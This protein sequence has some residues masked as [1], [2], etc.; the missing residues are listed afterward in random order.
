MAADRAHKRG[1]TP[2]RANHNDNVTY[3]DP[4]DA[5]LEDVAHRGLAPS[6][7]PQ[8]DVVIVGAGFAG[9]SAGALLA[10]RGVRVLVLEARGRL[11]GRATAFRDRETGEIV[12]NGQHVMFGCYRETLGF[13]DR[14]GARQNVRIQDALSIPFIAR[15]GQRSLLE[16]PCWPAPL[17]LLGGILRWNALPLRDRLSALR[18]APAM[19][20]ARWTQPAAAASTE[21]VL[22]WLRR[23]QQTERLIKAL[24]EPLAIAALNQPIAAAAAAPFI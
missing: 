13:L 11:G 8:P 4:A 1:L 22:D 20:R 9:L 16:C 6:E 12:D 14:I 24:W 18:I 23:H 2:I 21:T 10:D 5:D 19:A 3:K 17:H 15:S 7:R